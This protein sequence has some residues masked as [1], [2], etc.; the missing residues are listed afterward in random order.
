MLSPAIQILATL[1]DGVICSAAR[2]V[3]VLRA[4]HKLDAFIF[5]ALLELLG[6]E[7]YCGAVTSM[8][9]WSCWTQQWLQHSRLVGFLYVS[10][11]KFTQ[12]IQVTGSD[13]LN[14][15]EDGRKDAK[16]DGRED[17][18]KMGGEMDEQAR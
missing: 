10:V 17:G 8:V 18:E 15:R 14:G 4:R 9:S 2:G 6:L 5:T 13:L 7:K 3:S 16:N 1:E 11:T 12:I